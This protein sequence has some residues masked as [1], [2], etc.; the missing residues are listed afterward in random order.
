MVVPFFAAAIIVAYVFE[1]FRIMMVGS[2]VRDVLWPYLQS[3]TSASVPSW[4]SHRLAV[5]G[6]RPG[7]SVNVLWWWSFLPSESCF[8]SSL[9]TCPRCSESPH[10]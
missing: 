8:R 7:A 6:P 5:S 10:W 4:E 2:Y 1:S 3:Q 9:R